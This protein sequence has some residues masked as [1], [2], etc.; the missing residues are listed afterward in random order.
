MGVQTNQ[1]SG[2]GYWLDYK[3]AEAALEAKYDEDGI[4]EIFD[5][6]HDSA[7]D[8]EIVEVNGFSMIS[9][10]MSGEYFF[11]GKIDAKSEVHEPLDVAVAKVPSAKVKKALKEEIVNVFGT[12]FGIKPGSIVFTHYR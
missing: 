1:Y 12:D 10:G 4:E 5:K 7:Y 8:Q 3:Q 11:F 6:Y 2:F 9:D